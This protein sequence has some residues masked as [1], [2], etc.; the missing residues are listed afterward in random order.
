MESHYA[1][2]ES[3]NWSKRGQHQIK[4]RWNCIAHSLTSQIGQNKVNIELAADGMPL[5]TYWEF[6][7]VEARS[8]SNYKQMEWH[9]AQPESSNWSKRGQYQI[10]NTWNAIAH[11][12]RVRIGQSEVSIKLTTDAWHYVHPES[13]NW[14]KRGQYQISSPWNGITHG[15]RVQIDQNK[16]S[17]KLA[18]DR[19]P[20]RTSWEFKLVEARSTTYYQWKE[21]RRAHPESLNWSK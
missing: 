14:S 8:V 16:V 21:Q 5:R 20:L 1:H 6:E 15:L 9:Y 10:S 19:M 4:G 13:S 11:K 17:I 7:W 2:P 18:A 12:L 3:S